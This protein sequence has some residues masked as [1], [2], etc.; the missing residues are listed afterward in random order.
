MDETDLTLF[1]IFATH[2]PTQT[3]TSSCWEQFSVQFLSQRPPDMWTI[4]TSAIG[5]PILPTEPQPP[6]GILRELKGIFPHSAFMAKFETKSTN[7]AANVSETPL[8]AMQDDA[9]W[10]FMIKP[11]EQTKKKVPLHCKSARWPSGGRLTVFG[12][13]SE[14]VDDVEVRTQVTHDLQLGH[15]SLSLAPPCC[16]WRG[17]V[18]RNSQ[19]VNK[20]A[21]C[22]SARLLD[23]LLAA[24]QS[25]LATRLN[26]M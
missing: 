2:S 7:L 25:N 15:Q 22:L 10:W 9:P 8:K 16:G 19:S 11:N 13:G 6:E 5:Q 1:Y 12:A 23:D 4:I 14:Q 26:L 17:E 21:G 24:R 3:P 20:T 18:E